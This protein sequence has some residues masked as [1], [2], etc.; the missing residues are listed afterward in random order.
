M[1]ELPSQFKQSLCKEGRYP[2]LCSAALAVSLH[3]RRC[4]QTRAAWVAALSWECREEWAETSGLCGW[5][6]SSGGRADE[7]HCE[8]VLALPVRSWA[9]LSAWFYS[10][11]A[12]L[13][14]QFVYVGYT[15]FVNFCVPFS[16]RIGIREFMALCCLSCATSISLL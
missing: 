3:T 1:K 6:Q 2:R 7:A 15:C 4:R 13:P 16:Q 9:I 12:A 5:V 8:D 11:I 10:L 14:K